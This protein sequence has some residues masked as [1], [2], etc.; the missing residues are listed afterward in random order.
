MFRVFHRTESKSKIIVLY[1]ESVS[2]IFYDRSARKFA[3][4]PRTNPAYI[5]LPFSP[6]TVLT[7]TI[8]WDHPLRRLRR[9][10][11]TDKKKER[12]GGER[13]RAR[14]EKG[15]EVA[16]EGKNDENWAKGADNVIDSYF[17]SSAYFTII[18]SSTASM[19]RPRSVSYK[20]DALI[21]G[22]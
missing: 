7:K 11:S 9:F 4:K 10:V 19:L 5:L 21:Y 17:Y 3:A 15:K 14:R 13:R 2:L 8:S 1:I 20:P 22:G 6:S 16:K 12:G 18:L